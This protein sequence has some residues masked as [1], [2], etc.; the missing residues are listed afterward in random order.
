LQRQGT[1][2]TG[3]SSLDGVNWTVL[4]SQSIPIGD[5][6]LMG[7]AVTSHNNSELNTSTFDNVTFTPQP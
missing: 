3:S 6:I 1:T 5:P 7:L 2:I 4:G